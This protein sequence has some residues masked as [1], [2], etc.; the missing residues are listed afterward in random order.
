MSAEQIALRHGGDVS[1]ESEEGVGTAFFFR[2][3][4]CSIEEVGEV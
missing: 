4:E 2:F 3:P 1:V